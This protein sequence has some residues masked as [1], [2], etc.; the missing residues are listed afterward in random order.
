[1]DLGLQGKNVL[2]TGSTA[3]IGFASARRFA[4]E[5]A[6]VIVNGRT[7]ARV[8]AAVAAI[9]KEVPQARIRGVAADVS[10]LGG[11]RTLIDAV[12][13]VDVLVNNAGIFE[14]K[15]FEDIPDGDWMRFFETNVM[16]GV[17]LSRHYM[18]GMLARSWVAS[19]SCRASRRSRSPSR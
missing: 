19:S 5:G 6:A 9:A 1:M 17:R 4:A 12:P 14:P 18:R 8:D 7:T 3:G 11:V 13:E 15:P 16:S 2:V 10:S